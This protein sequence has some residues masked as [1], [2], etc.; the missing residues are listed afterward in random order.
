MLVLVLLIFAEK[1]NDY[2]IKSK[3][4][5]K[6]ELEKASKNMAAVDSYRYSLKSSFA[7]DN[8][9]E[10]ISEVRGEKN[11][12][13]THIKGEM[14]NTPVDI[15]YVDRTIYNYDSF[16]KN[17]LVIESD[18][19][20]S[21]ELLISELNPLSNFR[22]KQVDTVDK[23]KFE[24]VDGTECLVVACQPSVES[25]LLETLWEDFEYRLWIDYKK[26]FIRKAALNAVNKNNPNTKLNLEVRFFDFNKEIKIKPPPDAN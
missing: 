4:D 19:T 2:Y 21:E 12:E 14:V 26:G 10:V 13:N 5:P 20:N 22:F 23:L 25:Q 9:K 7:V 15:Y 17:W 16:S 1:I 24:K 8:R 18:T 3:L 6:V 11:K